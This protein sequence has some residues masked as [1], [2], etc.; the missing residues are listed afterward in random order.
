MK[1]FKNGDEV[2][3]DGEEAL[4]VYGPDSVGMYCI[5]HPDGSIAVEPGIC[6]K[7]KLATI[8]VNGVEVAKPLTK[9]DAD[10]CRV[11]AAPLTLFCISLTR[12][13]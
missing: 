1:E 4:V 6:L 7:P 3:M 2:L 5:K 12:F 10:D 8:S 11:T 9:D 13:K